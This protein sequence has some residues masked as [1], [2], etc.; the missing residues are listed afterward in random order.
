MSAP[1]MLRH[2]VL[3]AVVFL[4]PM[5]VHRE[6]FMEP[7]HWLAFV[8]GYLLLYTQP[9]PDP[10]QMLDRSADDKSSALWIYLGMSLP[11]LAASLDHAW[12]QSARPAAGNAWLWSGAVV[13]FASLGFRVWAIRTLG[14]FFTATVTVQNEQR[15]IDVGPYRLLRHP[16]YSGALGI[17]LGTAILFHSVVGIALVVLLSVPAYL[18]RMQVE[19][20]TLARDLGDAYVRY[21]TRTKRLLVAALWRGRGAILRRY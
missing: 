5:L 9:D 7:A 19:E 11:Q 2:I 18:Y 20:R 6:R 21:M 1:R 8:L 15:V 14:R 4:L 16:S 13:A 17:A 10:K 12:F 3:P